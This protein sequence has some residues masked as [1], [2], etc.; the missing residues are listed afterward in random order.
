MQALLWGDNLAIVVAHIETGI[1]LAVTL[2][3]ALVA[4]S[5]DLERPR[6]YAAQLLAA[7]LQLNVGHQI[8]TYDIREVS[9]R[10]GYLFPPDIEG[11]FYRRRVLA[12][13]IRMMA[14]TTTQMTM[15]S[16]HHLTALRDHRPTT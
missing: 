7:W 4:R 15:T 9:P 12:L 1:P 16:H 8:R 5:P 10:Q 2:P 13:V 14:R 6:D 3:A 11:G